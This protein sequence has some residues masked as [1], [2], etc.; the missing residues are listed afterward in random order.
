M[1]FAPEYI[2]FTTLTFSH[3]W[4]STLVAIHLQ[5]LKAKG[6]K[7]AGAA[8]LGRKTAQQ[9]FGRGEVDE[10]METGLAKWKRLWL[11]LAEED[12]ANELARLSSRTKKGTTRA[13][14]IRNLTQEHR[15]ANPWVPELES[16]DEAVQKA[17]SWSSPLLLLLL[18]LLPLG[19]L[20]GSHQENSLPS[21]PCWAH[22]H[23]VYNADVCKPHQILLSP[24]NR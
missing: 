9:A 21:A 4:N 11:G 12:A 1:H 7:K 14:G 16:Q 5:D 8:T 3:S 10:G 13:L 2:A 18:L 19:S 24:G 22:S 15:K 23:L 17:H 6:T 20:K